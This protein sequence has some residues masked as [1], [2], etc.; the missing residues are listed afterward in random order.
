MIHMA[1]MM[2]GL[3][4]QLAEADF[5]KTGQHWNITID[6]NHIVAVAERLYNS[7]FFLEDLCAID[8]EEGYQI[9][10]HFSSWNES[11]RIT[12][13]LLV[14]HERP[15]VPSIS[16]IFSGA[17]W[18]ER[19]CFDFHG[20]IFT[21]HP[22]LKPLLLPEDADFHPLRKVAEARRSLEK[23]FPLPP[24][25]GADEAA[26]AKGQNKSEGSEG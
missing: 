7:G 23:L 10:Y 3:N 24:K 6:T 22:D 14:P 20:V 16:S 4:A 9:V 11:T 1:S 13:R 21:G 2:E 12:A 8:A 15:E 25:P 5:Q 26:S 19:E 17:S 18:H